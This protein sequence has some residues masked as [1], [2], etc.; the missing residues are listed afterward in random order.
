MPEAAKSLQQQQLLLQRDPNF[1]LKTPPKEYY[2]QQERV[3]SVID[4]SKIIIFIKFTIGLKRIGSNKILFK[5]L[6]S[7]ILFQ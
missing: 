4:I 7:K 1:R 3:Q 2:R 6:I 5:F